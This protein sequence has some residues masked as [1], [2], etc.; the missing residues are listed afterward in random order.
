MLRLCARFLL[1]GSAHKDLSDPVAAFHLGNGASVERIN[2]L[3][4]TSDLRMRQS[5]GI[6][7]SYAYRVSEIERNH[8]QYVNKGRVPASEAVR[9]LRREARQNGLPGPLVSDRHLLAQLP[10]AP[11]KHS[12]EEGVREPSAA[13][14][15]TPARR[16][17]ATESAG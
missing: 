3:A 5:A 15:P 6:M 12:P 4:D 1:E 10:R 2:W 14:R 7:V 8:E 13:R 9:R 17:G 16:N 11:E